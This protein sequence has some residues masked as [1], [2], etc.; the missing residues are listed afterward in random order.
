M[1]PNGTKVEVTEL[2]KLDFSE[3]TCGDSLCNLPE[4]HATCPQDCPS[5]SN[6]EYCDAVR[7]GKCDPDC[8]AG[9][10]A[11]CTAVE[12]P[13]PL[14]ALGCMVLAITIMAFIAWKTKKTRKGKHSTAHH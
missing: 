12:P 14:L 13:N 10:D 8:S 7:D 1:L 6:D 9:Q 5:A 11:D 3:T 2:M 4:T